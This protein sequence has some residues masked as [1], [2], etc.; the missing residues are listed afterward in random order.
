MGVSVLV[1]VPSNEGINRDSA[2]FVN[3]NGTAHLTAF[4]DGFVVEQIHDRRTILP[5]I[6][7]LGSG[8]SGAPRSY[9]EYSHLA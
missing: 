1:S 6:L 9:P 8:G 7:D 2:V 4:D 3:R 5:D